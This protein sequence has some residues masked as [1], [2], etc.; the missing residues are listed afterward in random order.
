VLIT[1]QG[2][3]QEEAQEPAPEPAI[4]DLFVALAFVGKPQFYA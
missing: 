3:A 2:V 4:E 1:E